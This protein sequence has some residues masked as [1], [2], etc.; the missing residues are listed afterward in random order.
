MCSI[1]TVMIAYLGFKRSHEDNKD[2]DRR[3]DKDKEKLDNRFDDMLKLIQQQNQTFQEQQ[4]KNNEMLIN[5][6]IQGVTNHVPSDE[7]NNKLTKI[8]EEID[9]TLQQ[10]LIFTNADRVD[11]VQYHNGGKGVNKQSFLKMSMTNEQ[12]KI[13][14]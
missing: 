8:T 2:K 14:S 12:V 6:I 9:K 5:S 1:L 10:I 13:R 3:L 7:E 11:L 4:L